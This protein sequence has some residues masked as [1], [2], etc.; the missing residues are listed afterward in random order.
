MPVVHNTLEQLKAFAL[1]C[2]CPQEVK[3]NRNSGLI[4]LIACLCMAFDHFGK[5]CFPQQSWMRLVGRLAFPLFAYGISVGV[6]HTKDPIEYLRRLVLLALVSQPLYSLGLAHEN[7]AMYAVSFAEHPLRAAWTF[8]IKSFTT[9]S[10]L[11][12]LCAALTLLILLRKKQWLLAFFVYILLERFGMNLDYGL[13]GIRLMLVF[14]FLCG[15]PLLCACAVFVFM[16]QNSA[17]YG[18]VF[19]GQ[20][21][22]MRI[23]ALP[24]ALF[25]CLPLQSG[26]R[27]PRWLTY[28]FYPA[29]LLL[30][31]LITK[32]G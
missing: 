5:M 24:A 2:L 9:P 32:L 6:I 1:S 21:F 7:A 4:K 25:A 11:I 15:H 30:L 29:H 3:T 23:F 10:I 27:A 17:G 8:Y 13:F 16:I 18:Y 12:T 31:A 28:G 22:S 20:E 26:F 19:F 14:Y